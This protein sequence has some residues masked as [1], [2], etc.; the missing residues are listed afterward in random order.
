MTQPLSVGARVLRFVIALLAGI[1]L[2]SVVQTQINLAAL[3]ALGV[4]IP[5]SVRASTTGKDLIHFAPPLCS[6]TAAWVCHVTG[7]CCAD[8]SPKGE[9]V[10]RADS[11]LSGR[12]RAVGHFLAG[13]CL[14]AHAHVDCGDSR[15]VRVGSH[16]G[17]GRACGVAI[18]S[19][20]TWQE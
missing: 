15:A 18:G 5:F 16:A 13:E 6:R 20:H 4:A 14:C 10:S 11:R 19:A 3:Q 2:G 9:E 1:I 12:G 17:Y 7:C 8:S